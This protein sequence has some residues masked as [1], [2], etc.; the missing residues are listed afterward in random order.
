MC[1]LYYGQP[2]MAM[3]KY[4]NVFVSQNKRINRLNVFI[5]CIDR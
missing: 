2:K 1:V 3:A 5:D 4:K